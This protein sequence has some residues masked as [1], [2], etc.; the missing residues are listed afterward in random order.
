MDHDDKIGI[1]L[2]CTF[3]FSLVSIL[4]LAFTSTINQRECVVSLVMEKASPS[5]AAFAYK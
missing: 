3:V 4:V 2:I 1:T 5:E